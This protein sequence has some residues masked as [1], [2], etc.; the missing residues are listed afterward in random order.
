MDF[1]HQPRI[2][3]REDYPVPEGYFEDLPLKVLT[4]MDQDRRNHGRPGP[5]LF[6]RTAWAVAASLAL[7]LGAWFVGRSWWSVTPSKDYSAAPSDFL[8]E[9][10]IEEIHEA[11]MHG[12]ILELIEEVAKANP[13]TQ[14]DLEASADEL[15]M[16]PVT[17]QDAMESLPND[18]S[19]LII[20]GE[21]GL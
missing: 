5:Q 19:D 10:S 3:F 11:A 14:T 1:N 13:G 4:R 12:A 2:P 8:A 21:A 20:E 18:L 9:A 17:L 15:R 6:G 7:L 16:E